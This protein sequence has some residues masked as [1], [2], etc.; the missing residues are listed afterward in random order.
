MQI[1]ELLAKFRQIATTAK[2]QG[3]L[4]EELVCKILRNS[5]EYPQ[6]ERVL[7]WKD[8]EKAQNIADIGIDLVVETRDGYAVGSRAAFIP[9][10]T[11]VK[12]LYDFP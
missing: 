8:W 4:F 2:E 3:D 7:F 9:N 6:I 1:A 5:P 10:R 12:N 11:R